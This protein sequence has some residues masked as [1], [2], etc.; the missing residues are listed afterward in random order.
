MSTFPYFSLIKRTVVVKIPLGYAFD[1]MRILWSIREFQY[2]NQIES[3]RPETSF[4]MI[5]R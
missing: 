4:S 3:N 5:H 1:V 2:F